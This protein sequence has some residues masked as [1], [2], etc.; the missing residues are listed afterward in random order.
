MQLFPFDTLFSVFVL[1]AV[2]DCSHTSII[3]HCISMSLLSVAVY[4]TPVNKA[5]V[6]IHD[7]LT[8]LDEIDAHGN[9]IGH[10]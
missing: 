8:C 3:L 7:E 4:P 10:H 6:A 2:H 5:S 9:K 1:S